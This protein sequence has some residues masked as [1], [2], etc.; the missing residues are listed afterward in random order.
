ME[1]VYIPY[2]NNPYPP[3]PSPA[4]TWQE[5]QSDAFMAQ[6]NIA[7]LTAE[8]NAIR[9]AKKTY[10]CR[11]KYITALHERK[12]ERQTLWLAHLEQAV[13]KQL[14]AAAEEIM[15][16]YHDAVTAAK[17]KLSTAPEDQRAV[18]QK[19]VDDAEKKVKDDCL[20]VAALPEFFW[21]DINDNM[22]HADRSDASFIQGYG[23]PV[24]PQVLQ[25]L[26]A[27]TLSIAAPPA[28]AAA[29]PLTLC[30]LTQKYPNLVVFAGTVWWK[31]IVDASQCTFLK[32][33]E[34]TNIPV[35]S[36]KSA[37]KAAVAKREKM[38]NTLPVFH[39]GSCICLWNKQW[40]SRIDGLGDS[41]INAEKYT[42]RAFALSTIKNPHAAETA[43]SIIG[44]ESGTTISSDPAVTIRHGGM[45][46]VFG[47]DICLD[48][49]MGYDKASK[50][51]TN[52]PMSKDL[53]GKK[54]DIQMLIAGGMPSYEYLNRFYANQY[55]LRCDKVADRLGDF[56]DVLSASRVAAASPV[57]TASAKEAR[58][59]TPSA[60]KEPFTVIKLPLAPSAG[61]PPPTP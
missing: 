3:P 15:Q 9:A 39:G 25:R 52:G 57:A 18:V 37:C 10:E 13:C 61:S 16:P 21:R 6:P 22:K 29:S 60:G 19:E 17:G 31:K 56:A 30:E 8:I 45:D 28:P 40:I 2:I 46:Y 35:G 43:A 58:A 24:Y 33:C 55:L 50:K 38:F 54:P 11:P 1:L 59:I 5:Q 47:M 41:Y 23:K 26:T 7:A 48:Y 27:G 12:Q 53:L 14:D 32:T 44:L 36:V 49:V 4:K 20:M 51:M 42:N 34:S